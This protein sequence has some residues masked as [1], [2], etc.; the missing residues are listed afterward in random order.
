MIPHEWAVPEPFA[1]ALIWSVLPPEQILAGG[2]GQREPEVEVH[3][4][5][6][7]FIVHNQGGQRRLS[8]LISTD[9]LDYLS[10][11]FAPGTELP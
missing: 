4:Q 2:M 6:R 7:I 10:T 8:R 11:D 3:H 9:P 1:A 5:G